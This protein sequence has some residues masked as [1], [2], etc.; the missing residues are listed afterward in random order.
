MWPQCQ[1]FPGCVERRRSNRALQLASM[2]LQ[3]CRGRHIPR[4]GERHSLMEKDTHSTVCRKLELAG[5]AGA[6]HFL[7]L[8]RLHV[9]ASRMWCEV[10][11]GAVHVE[12]FAGLQKVEAGFQNL[13]RRRRANA[14]R[15]NR[16]HQALPFC[17][18][19]C[20]C[21]VKPALSVHDDT[22]RLQQSPVC[23]TSVLRIEGRRSSLTIRSLEVIFG[24]AA[25]SAAFAQAAD[26]HSGA[27]GHMLRQGMPAGAGPGA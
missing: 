24:T 11:Q 27:A 1:S 25:L 7:Q 2:R 19:S 8:L 12:S 22:F 5:I 13:F 16:F 3:Y 6:S 14:T 23:V 10:Q 4:P 17:T 21:T 18:A 9:P 20:W 26:C 15:H